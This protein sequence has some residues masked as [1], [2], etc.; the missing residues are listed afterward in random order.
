[1]VRLVTALSTESQLP[2]PALLEAFGRSLFGGLHRSY[3]HFFKDESLF[4]FLASIHTYIHVEVKKL[5]PDAE[6]PSLVVETRTPEKL[7]LLYAS[8][9]CMGDLARGLLKAAIAHFGEEAVELS[10]ER[11]TRDGSQMRFTLTRPVL[12]G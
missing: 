1:M 11:V 12:V 2:V 6:L 9:R 5:Y 3:P 4:D 8:P 10:E 7:A